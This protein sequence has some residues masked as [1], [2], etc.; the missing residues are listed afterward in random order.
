MESG[1]LQKLKTE[2]ENKVLKDWL[3]FLFPYA[4][5]AFELEVN[6]YPESLMKFESIE[7]QLR[8]LTPPKEN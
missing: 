7:A 6:K 5:K 3:L 1:V 4:K 2:H 8:Y